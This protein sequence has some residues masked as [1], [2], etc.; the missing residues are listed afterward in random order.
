MAQLLTTP[1]RT[2]TKP[3]SVFKDVFYAALRTQLGSLNLAQEKWLDATTEQNYRDL[4]KKENFQP[5]SI[6]LSDGCKAHWI[7]AKKKEK[8]LV[9]LHGG[10]R[11]R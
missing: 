7:G 3:P 9:Y 10:L 4:A 1:I 5:D 8:V 6:V 2:G 11:K